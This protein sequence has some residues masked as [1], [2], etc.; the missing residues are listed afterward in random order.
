VQE[1][2]V[3]VCVVALTRLQLSPRQRC[4]LRSYRSRCLAM[5]GRS[6]SDILT[7][8]RHATILIYIRF[9][10]LLQWS[11]RRYI[12]EYETLDTDLISPNSSTDILK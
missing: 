2:A 10:F 9:D 7:F 11:I 8:S 12:P 1:T 6:H 5:D 3:Y 4:T